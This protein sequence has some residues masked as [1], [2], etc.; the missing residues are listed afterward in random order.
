MPIRRVGEGQRLTHVAA[1]REPFAVF[2]QILGEQRREHCVGVSRDGQLD[3]RM[4][5]LQLGFVDVDVDNRRERREF[6]IVE[7]CLL[8]AEPRA[9]RYHQIGL[10][11]QHVRRALTPGV[12]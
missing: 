10:L 1:E 6:A 9:E 7:A 12:G 4:A 3:V 11:E 8:Q 2:A 5:L